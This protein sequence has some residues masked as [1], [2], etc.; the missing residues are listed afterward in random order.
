[1]NN[2][3]KQTI[4]Q[5]DQDKRGAHDSDNDPR[6]PPDRHVVQPSVPVPEGLRRPRVGPDH[7]P[8]DRSE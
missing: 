2:N 3:N 8:I 1:M 5:T 4:T 6:T 7:K